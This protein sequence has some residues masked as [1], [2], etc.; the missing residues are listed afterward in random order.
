MILH[1]SYVEINIIVKKTTLRSSSRK[2]GGLY[3]LPLVPQMH[4]YTN[5]D[6][7]RIHVDQLYT[8]LY[9]SLTGA[10]YLNNENP[11]SVG[12]DDVQSR[13]YICM[14]GLFN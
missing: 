12:G 5:D 8:A 1:L 6:S 11:L 14:F 13:V 7:P 10:Y 4:N 3:A 2:S 9:A